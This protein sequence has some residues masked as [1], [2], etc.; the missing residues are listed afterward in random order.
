MKDAE[1]QRWEV[2]DID[3]LDQVLFAV[4]PH[5]HGHDEAR[6]E[7]PH[8]EQLKSAHPRVPHPEELA[9]DQVIRR[10]DRV[11]DKV[12]DGEAG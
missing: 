11:E 10:E 1:R 6:R 4:S 8:K 2:E 9:C 12:E 3:F 7:T 5:I